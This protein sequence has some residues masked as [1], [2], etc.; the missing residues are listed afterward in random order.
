[1]TQMGKFTGLDMRN[2]CLMGIGFF[3]FFFEGD[4]N[5]VP[6]LEVMFLQPCEYAKDC[7]LGHF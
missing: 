3:F 7:C 6:E 2:D 1:M 4:D 5:N